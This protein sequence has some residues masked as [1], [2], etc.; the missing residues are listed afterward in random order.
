VRFFRALRWRRQREDDLQAEI[1]AH[2]AMDARERVAAGADP[3]AAR[4]AA[5]KEFGNLTLTREATRLTWGALWIDRAES[6]WRDLTYAIR[7]LV[8]SPGYSLVVAGVLAIGIG[9]NLIAFGLFQALAVAP[10]SG[11]RNSADLHFIVATTI[12]YLQGWIL[13]R[14]ADARRVFGELVTGNF[15]GVLGVRAQ[16]G[17]TLTPADDVLGQDQAVALI[18]YTVQQSRH[19]IGIRM[20][21]GAPRS[22]VL[23]RFLLSGVR[24]GLVG[25]VLGVAA[26]AA[27]AR[28]MAGL[29]Y[30]VTA[31]DTTSFLAASAA[32]AATVVAASLVPA[33]RASLLDPLAALRRH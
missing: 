2:L 8:H 30:G 17:R 7:L 10:L 19:E 28:L 15:F 31:A 21:V 9:V 33:W 18:A 5:L 13:G 29:L 20:A 4:L 27:V 32:V 6:V 3:E 1:A 26:A 11:V 14:G 23:S 25:S 24:L 22:S 12:S 16:L